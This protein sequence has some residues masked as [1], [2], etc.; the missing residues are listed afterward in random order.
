[1]KI[2]TEQLE[3]LRYKLRMMGL[4]VNVYC[5]NMSVFK[6]AVFPESTL[7]KKH[8]SISYHKTRETKDAG[9]VRIA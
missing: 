5:D 8:D 1:M 7:Q 4:P 9:T 3:G 2:A 6:S